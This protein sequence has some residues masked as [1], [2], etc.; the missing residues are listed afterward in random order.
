MRSL[1]PMLSNNGFFTDDAL[2]FFDNFPVFSSHFKIPKVDIEDL[3]DHYE[4][5]ADL[6]GFAKDQI[7]V[8][9][10]DN[11]LTIAAKSEN[12]KE[13]KDDDK[14]YIRRERGVSAFKRQFIVDGI[15]KENIKANLKDGILKIELPKLKIEDKGKDYQIEIGE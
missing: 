8:T 14:H 1:L 5:T 13:T 2:D 10:Q 4:V 9:Y 7:S 15:N 6:P 11:V 12:S 3:K